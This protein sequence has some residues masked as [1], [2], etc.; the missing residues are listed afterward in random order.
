M[1]KIAALFF[2]LFLFSFSFLLNATPAQADCSPMVPAPNLM[3]MKGNK[4]EVM[5]KWNQV[6]NASRYALVYGYMPM[7]YQFGSLSIDGGMQTNYTVTMLEPGKTYYFQIWAFCSDD[8]P[9]TPSN[10][11]KFVSP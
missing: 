7:N 5:L 6:T 3:A 1:K 9:A 2:A 4:G 11:V 8:Q 10:E